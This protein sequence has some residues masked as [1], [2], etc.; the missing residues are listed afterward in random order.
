MDILVDG[1]PV[2]QIGCIGGPLLDLYEKGTRVV[3]FEFR[4]DTM[5]GPTYPAA[6]FEELPVYPGSWMDF[7][8]C[9]D[10]TIEYAALAELLETFSH[11]VLKWCK[12][13][14]LYDGKGLPEGKTSFTFRFQL[15]LRERTL[16]GDD[17]TEFRDAFLVFLDKHGLSLR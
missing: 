4:C 14:Y 3:W 12:F 6:G 16:T 5:S 2:G 8:I 13:L 7:S 15:G 9:A 1:E 17:L 11:P 10:K